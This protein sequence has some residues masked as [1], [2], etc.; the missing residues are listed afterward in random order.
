VGQT[1][2]NVTLSNHGNAPL[3]YSSTVATEDGQPWLS[4]I[5]ANGSVP[6]NGTTLIDVQANLAGLS[7]GLWRGTVRIAFADGT[8]ARVAVVLVVTGAPNN[9]SSTSFQRTISLA[10]AVNGCN[11][12]SDLAV[13]FNSPADSFQVPAR[14]PVPLQVLAIDCAGNAVT[15]NAAA[16]VVVQ[17]PG[18]PDVKIP[19]IRQGSGLW[20]A[21]WTPAMGSS[22][23][24]LLARVNKSM[25]GATAPSGMATLSGAVQEAAADAVISVMNGARTDVA[26]ENAAGAW[27]TI[28]GT[29]LADGS[30]A[31]ATA[32]YPGTLSGT[33][34]F[35]Q[36]HPLPLSFV[37]PGQ[38]NA[39]IPAG[40]NAGT[41]QLTVVRNGTRSTGMDVLVSQ[42]G[43]GLFSLD[44][45]GQGQGAILAANTGLVAGPLHGSQEGPAERGQRI[46]IY[47]TGL[48]AVN[49][50]PPQDGEATPLSPSLT[51]TAT[52][53]VTIGGVAAPLN[54]SGLA[55]TL[56]GIYVVD[57]QVPET[58]GPG[59]DVPVMLTIGGLTSNTVAISVR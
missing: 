38:I 46:L 53:K 25:G 11:T 13:V 3:T 6:A 47:C 54:F 51:T 43:P 39:L 40:M 32:P 35:M 42:M 57:V 2:Q 48:G 23:V 28:M 15:D 50:D 4:E 49:G 7:P 58:V 27:V 41:Q 26:A 34:V 5:P 52:P 9:G 31:A 22:G 12:N 19:L 30:F 24:T 37:S 44:G 33:Q 14:R 29:G 16:D 59:D 21:T 17:V 10:S 20:T 1:G 8:L 36:N 56:V 18:A 55:P 45:S